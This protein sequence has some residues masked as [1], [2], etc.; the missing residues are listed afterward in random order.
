MSGH[1]VILFIL[2]LTSCARENPWEKQEANLKALITERATKEDAIG[3]LGTNFVD[4]SKPSNRAAFA[5]FLQGEPSNRWVQV[6]AKIEKWPDALY[7]ST[8]ELMSWV[9]LDKS[10]RVV[11]YYIGPQ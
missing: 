5:L 2:S 7:Y 8:P 6:R 4:H 11:D 3:L 10:N 9:F 1:K